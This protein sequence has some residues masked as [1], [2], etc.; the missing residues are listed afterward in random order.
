[1]AT[2]TRA[3]LAHNACRDGAACA[4]A[5]ESGV[6]ATLATLKAS[7]LAK[8]VKSAVA[9]P[10]SPA[11]V[12]KPDAAAVANTDKKATA[13]E[14]PPALE[15]SEEMVSSSSSKKAATVAT[16]APSPSPRVLRSKLKVVIPPVPPFLHEVDLRNERERKARL[17]LQSE[18]EKGTTGEEDKEDEDADYHTP[19]KQ[20][21]QKRK[22]RSALDDADDELVFQESEYRMSQ[23]TPPPSERMLDHKNPPQPPRKAKKRRRIS[24]P[25]NPVT[26]RMTFTA[27]SL[28]RLSS[29]TS[30]SVVSASSPPRFLDTPP[31]SP[32]SPIGL[33]VF[34]S[35]ADEFAAVQDTPPLR[36][37]RAPPRITRAARQCTPP[38]SSRTRGAI[39]TP[40]STMVLRSRQLNPSK[41]L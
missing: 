9:K 41:T 3:D 8:R 4:V 31:G 12:S 6:S 24:R 21:T 39:Q 1:M 30:S 23:I 16:A 22:S 40:T 2:R 17:H 36:T 26:G 14:K 28:P 13:E 34:R 7:P 38:I 18:E 33:S 29:E 10:A 11:F 32:R 20:Q 37:L 15:A 35:L 25:L 5:V 27:L 19:E